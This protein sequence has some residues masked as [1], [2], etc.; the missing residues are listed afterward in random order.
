MRLTPKDIL[1]HISGGRVLDLAAGSGGF[2]HFLIDGLKDYTEIIGVDNDERAA[3]AFTDAFKDHPNVHFELQDAAQLDFEDSSF[4]MVCIS[5]S[6]H[7][8]DPRPALRQMKRILRP[9]GSLLVSEM[10]RDKQT[11]TQLTHVH[12]HHWWAA[13]DRINGVVHHE[14]YRRAEIL[15]LVY[16]L[17]LCNEVIYEIHDLE[18]DPK[19]PAI[20]AELNPVFEQ[21]IQRAARHPHLQARGEKL[22]KRVEQV[23]FH[24]ATTLVIIGQKP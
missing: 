12:L 5:N 9:G 21:Y 11:E 18:A 3:S 7:H 13:V 16:G 20:I 4:D 8:L 10:I 15:T 19:D 14:T 23:G 22:R 2:V 24:S 1:G 17:G 6:L